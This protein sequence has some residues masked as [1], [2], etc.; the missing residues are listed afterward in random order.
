MTRARVTRR[1]LL[2]GSAAVITVALVDDLCSGSSAEAATEPSAVDVQ[3]RTSASTVFGEDFLTAIPITKLLGFTADGLRSGSRPIGVT[4]DYDTRSQRWTGGPVI[5]RA[6]VASGEAAVHATGTEPRGRI[7]FELPSGAGSGDS[8]EV[9]LPLAD[10]WLYPHDN[11]G[12]LATPVLSASINDGLPALTRT[13]PRGVSVAQDIAWGVEIEVGWGRLPLPGGADGD[14]YVFPQVVLVHS[15]GPGAVPSGSVL[16]LVAD[17]GLVSRMDL[18]TTQEDS[19]CFA[20]RPPGDDDDETS[21]TLARDLA[22]GNQLALVF[23]A[24]AVTGAGLRDDI[25][26]GRAWLTAPTH[27]QAAQRHTRRE[28]AVPSSSPRRPAADQL[29]D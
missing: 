26:Y 19:L 22:P 11:T 12:A 17:H 20:R 8:I 2:L 7:T 18:D 15:T 27:A 3:L 9:A 21:W 13:A 24:R 6:A 1:S 5:W 29:A 23:T 4:V 28:S 14:T 16:H 10:V 25:T